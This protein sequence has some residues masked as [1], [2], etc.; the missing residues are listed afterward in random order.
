MRLIFILVVFIL[1]LEA[2]Y[3][4][5]NEV[6]SMPNCREKDYFIWRFLSQ[7][8][9]TKYQAK[10]IIKGA[11][12]INSKLKKAYYKKTRQYP[13][14][15]K[16]PLPP[17]TKAQKRAWREKV[18]K[19][20]LVK[21]SLNP[22]LTLM[23]QKADMQTFIFNS[24]SKKDRKKFN[25]IL[26]PMQYK[27]LTRSKKFNES[28][29]LIKKENLKYI[30]KSFL[31]APALNNSLTFKTCFDLAL[32]A[33]EYNKKEIAII[34]FGE[35]R[36]KAYK[37][38]FKDQASFW[39]FLLTQ[40]NIYLNSLKNSYSVN[41][42][43][44]LARDKMRLP[45]PKTITPNFRKQRIKNFDIS[46][47]ISWAKLKKKIFNKRLNKNNLSSQFKSIET[48]AHYSYIKSVAIKY[49]RAYYPMPYRTTLSHLSKKRQA[50]LYALARQ[51]SRFIPASIST[52]FALGM[53]QIMPFLVKDIAKQRGEKMDYDGMFNP[54]TAL[55]YANH[56]LNYLDKWLYNPLLVA[57]AY[58]GG[59]GFT[60]RQLTQ[61]NRFKNRKYEPFLSMELID[62]AETR[63]Y[64]KKVLTNYVI[65]LNKLGIP[66][67]IS[68]LLKDLKSSKKV[69]N[70]R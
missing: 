26:T 61:K 64:G 10:K 43:T 7:S 52:S 25:H 55:K 21:K 47:P 19:S 17:A 13:K 48:I 49:K 20:K 42:Y 54:Y 12:K 68:N 14:L 40:E 31:F 5:F 22:Y 35:A 1:S 8:S 63:E 30:A 60:K 3:Y 24:A 51:E 23:K 18:K 36:K 16:K 2:K 4:N 62:S 53:M 56:H 29:E 28:I 59:I 66:I 39:L 37:R 50:M 27:K 58:N 34:Y 33:L 15:T 41:V 32:N 57:Y 11:T 6:N 69:D 67:R 70:F 9:T 65:Y 38:E 45:Y 46:D 44:L